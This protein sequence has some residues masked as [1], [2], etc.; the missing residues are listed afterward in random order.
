MAIVDPD[1]TRQRTAS[2]PGTAVPLAA[3][4]HG[5]DGNA[6]LTAANGLL[7]TVLLAIEGLTILSVRSLI[8]IHIFIG[9]LLVTPIALKIATTTYRF[10][11]YYG[12]SEA[13]VRRGPPPMFLRMLAPPLV[14]ATAAMMATGVL[15][16]TR[17]PGDAGTLLTL[18]KGSFIVW[19][20][21]MTVHFLG[22]I[23]ESLRLTVQEWRGAPRG[24]AARRART[25]RRAT[26]TWVLVLTLVAGVALAAAVTPSNSWSGHVPAEQHDGG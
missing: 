24:T 7:L 9:L 19:V 20:A 25:P 22:H 13:Y 11:R 3:S 18:H 10:V 21:L 14:I 8:T 6:K 1:P 15:L 17:K 12:R 23:A 2:E 26:R 5:V 4:D 16:L